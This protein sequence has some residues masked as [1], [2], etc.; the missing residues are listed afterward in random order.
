MSQMVEGLYRK[1]GGELTAALALHTDD[2]SL[3]EGMA[4]D[5][6]LR[7]LAAE[8][9]LRDAHDPRQWLFHTGL[10]LARKRRLPIRPRYSF[11]EER[12][13]LRSREWQATEALG[14]KLQA[15]TQ[16]QRDIIYLREYAGLNTPAVAAALRRGADAIDVEAAHIAQALGGVPSPREAWRT[17]AEATRPVG[18]ERLEDLTYADLDGDSLPFPLVGIAAL[19]LIAV[20][21][22]PRLL[23]GA[24]EPPSTTQRTTTRPVATAVS[25]SA[26]RFRPPLPAAAARVEC[27]AG[28]RAQRRAVA[29]AG[30]S[31]YSGIQQWP[32]P[33][34]TPY[35]PVTASRD[36]LHIKSRYVW[37]T[38]TGRKFDS[39][40]TEFWFDQRNGD[41]RYVETSTLFPRLLVYVRSGRFYS[42]EFPLEQKVDL[43][44]IA[45]PSKPYSEPPQ[46]IPFKYR[47]L[48]AENRVAGA[49]SVRFRGRPA[50]LINLGLY[51]HGQLVHKVWV[52]RETKLPL[53][54]VGYYVN[55][56]R[57]LERRE[58]QDFEYLR[59][60]RVSRRSLS[61]DIFAVRREVAES[62][63]AVRADSS[64]ATPLALLSELGLAR[65]GNAEVSA[66]MR[67][68][69]ARHNGRR[70]LGH[71]WLRGRPGTDDWM[72]VLDER[73]RFDS[74]RDA[75][76]FVAR[77]VL[78]AP[79]YGL[80]KPTRLA[81]APGLG[82]GAN[83][84]R[85]R[86]KAGMRGHVYYFTFRKNNVAA[87]MIVAGDQTLTQDL[88]FLVAR[89]ARDTMKVPPG[90]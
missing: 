82:A 8:D 42:V 59:N 69:L 68:L 14:A 33:V 35:K 58:T 66:P 88:A 53:R 89:I 84:Y 18:G 38:T 78:D 77:S 2:A 20:F 60:E 50:L 10:H 72:G 11:A 80:P 21:L 75:S 65:G 24:E 40:H 43:H 48:F 22:A 61:A 13:L 41:A 79:E 76:A 15:L 83:A 5:V 44:L 31:I 19:V 32:A 7:A 12:P 54:V 1:H 46:S 73:Y 87:R 52:D 27:D 71:E 49:R 86:L 57:L 16:A 26:S 47:N 23:G 70:L 62:T 6:F 55:T 36:V 9:D 25:R 81:G 39:G 3:A 64:L 34:R 56:R 45:D 67:A 4:H 85:G 37:R 30:D 28:R 17:L 63:G 74:V 29:C 51:Q 90:T